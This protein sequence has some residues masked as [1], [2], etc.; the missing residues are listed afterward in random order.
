M[1]AGML[2]SRISSSGPGWEATMRTL[3]VSTASARAM[4]PRKGAV[5]A[6]VGARS[7]VM[8]SGPKVKA[9]SSAVTGVP[10]WK[11][12][13]GRSVTSTVRSSRGRRDAA[14]RGT[15]AKSRSKS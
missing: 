6:R 4:V 9:M 11:R 3:R 5:V 7:P 14:G 12:A 15:G 1:P 8:R 2:A 10:S 13:S